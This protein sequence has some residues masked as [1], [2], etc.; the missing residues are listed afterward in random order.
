MKYLMKIISAQKKFDPK[1]EFENIFQ[2][3]NSYVYK[4]LIHFI[5]NYRNDDYCTDDEYDWKLTFIIVYKLSQKF[6]K[7]RNVLF[8]KC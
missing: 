5:L 2:Q 8:K 4:L 3:N 7:E 1:K 6:F